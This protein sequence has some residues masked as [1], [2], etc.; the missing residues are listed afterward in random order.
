MATQQIR[1]LDDALKTLQ[2][3]DPV[4]RREAVKRLKND[5]RPIVSAIKAGLPKAPLSNWVAPKQSSARRGTVQAGRSG[6][7]G[8]PYWDFGKAKSGVRSSVKKQGARQMK[9]KA[10]LVSIRQSNGAGE[11]FDMAGK[12]TNST[13]TRN[14]TNKWGGASRR[15][16][17]IAEKNKPAVLRSID[18][19]VQ[20]M[21]KQINR[22][23]R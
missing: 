4:L 20:D 8:T 9:G 18:Q 23:L 15:M 21:E 7:A 3:M 16:W 12:K 22:M 5:V 2:K 19:S 10:I 11:V 13:F 17:P 1:G 6:A 14:L